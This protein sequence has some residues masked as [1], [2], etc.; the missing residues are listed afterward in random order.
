MSLFVSSYSE[1]HTKRHIN[2]SWK[3]LTS[4][5]QELDR[6]IE[7]SG[8]KLD[9]TKS[10]LCKVMMAI[11][12]KECETAFVQSRITLRLRTQSLLDETDDFINR[13]GKMLDDFE[14]DDKEWKR[15]GRASG[16]DFWK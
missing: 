8:I 7:N 1:K 12:A 2:L 9:G 11:G 13:T 4:R 14:K 3:D 5:E 6:C 16:F 15:K 10:C